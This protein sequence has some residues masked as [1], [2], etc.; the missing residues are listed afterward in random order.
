MI[1][2]V[3]FL[4]IIFIVSVRTTKEKTAVNTTELTNPRLTS[5]AKKLKSILNLSNIKSKA[6]KHIN[7]VVSFS[8]QVEQLKVDKNN[9]EDRNI[10]P[11]N[12]LKY[13][14]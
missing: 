13:G 6:T 2:I 4:L 8:G 5:D 9:N 1:L 12:D 7:K 3:L 14:K 10:I 11:I